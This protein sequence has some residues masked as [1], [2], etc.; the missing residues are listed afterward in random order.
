M[1]S[2][3]LIRRADPGVARIALENEGCFVLSAADGEEALYLSRTFPGA[4]HLLLTDVEMPRMDGLQLRQKLREERPA[5]TV[6]IT[7]GQQH[8]LPPEQAFLPKPFT[9]GALRARVRAMLTPSEKPS[10][11]GSTVGH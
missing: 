11:Q 8:Q 9:L 1:S 3:V 6:L 4:I 7:S 5:I 2:K 10:A